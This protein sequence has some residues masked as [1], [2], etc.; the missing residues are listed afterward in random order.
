M[1]EKMERQREQK[2]LERAAAAANPA[3]TATR[4]TVPSG[5]NVDLGSPNNV[6][7][8]ETWDYQNRG[9]AYEET[10]IIVTSPRRATVSAADDVRYSLV[11]LTLLTTV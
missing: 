4:V 6:A 10:Q 7:S 2:R 5:S 1:R 9:Y 8:V 3:A 11:L